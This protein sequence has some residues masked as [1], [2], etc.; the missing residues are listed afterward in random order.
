MQIF[1]RVFVCSVCSLA[2]LPAQS[3]EDLL[4]D[5]G[6]GLTLYSRTQGSVN[7]AGS[8]IKLD[9][10]V[11]YNFNQYLGID[12][13]VPVYIINPASGKSAS[14][15]G[16]RQSTAL[17]NLYLDLRFTLTRPVVNFLTYLTLAA[18]TGDRNQ[19]FSTGHV[20]YDW[21]NHL[22]RTFGRFTPF[23]SAGLA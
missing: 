8:V 9:S 1:A 4:E 12:L 15:L 17:G 6:H 23:A 7:Q 11:G 22:S 18:P 13:G 19:G 20:T 10:N 14:S 5:P 21:H 2:L 3:L 16:T